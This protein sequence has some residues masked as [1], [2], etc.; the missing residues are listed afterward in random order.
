MTIAE[1]RKIQASVQLYKRNVPGD[2]PDV[3][4]IG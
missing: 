2:S 3:W 1:P 4:L